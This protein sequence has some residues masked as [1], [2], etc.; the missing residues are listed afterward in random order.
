MTITMTT[1]TTDLASVLT[2]LGVDIKRAGDKEISGCCPV[3]LSRTGHVDRSPSWSMNA[4]NGLWICYSCGAR[5]TLTSLLSELTGDDKSIVDVH[6]FLIQSGL[7][8]MMSSPEKV[9]EEPDIDW[10]A[11]SKFGPVPDLY[12]YNRD[13]SRE[14]THHYGVRWDVRNKAWIIPIVSA[15]GELLGWQTKKVDW[16]RNYPIGVKKS[17]TLFGV[18]RFTNKPA[19]LVESPLDVVRLATV[20]KDVQGLAT[21]GAY[22]S[23]EQLKLLSA[24]ASKVIVAM[25]NDEAGIKASKSLYKALPRFKDGVLWLDYKNTNAK[26]IGD[27]KSDEILNAVQ[28]ATA[29]PSWVL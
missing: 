24:V 15:S 2:E 6:M 18:E 5:G 4:E 12:L 11:Y 29:I 27:M 1:G 13:L 16:V 9:E 25:D 28:N 26:D 10:R 19:V 22:V 14:A 23:S 21:F 8:R 20:C 7:N 3:H 17:H